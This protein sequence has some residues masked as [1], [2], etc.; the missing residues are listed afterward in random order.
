MGWPGPIVSDSASYQVFSL[1]WRQDSEPV[2]QRRRKRGQ[3]PRL[4]RV[5]R[6]GATFTS[7]IDGTR[8]RLTPEASM[9]TQEALGADI[10]LAFDQPTSPQHD[11]VY[12]EH[13]LQRTHAWAQRCLAA[14]T[15]TDQALFGV[16]QGGPFA[17]LRQ[18]SARFIGSLP[19]DGVA[20][21]TSTADAVAAIDWSMPHVPER[22]PRHVPGIGQPHELF[23]CV[24]RGI[25]QFDSN[26]PTRLAR[27]GQLFTSAGL[28]SIQDAD[29]REDARPIDSACGCA[30][31]REGF[32]RAYL[33]HLFVTDELLGYT[34]ASVH[35]LHFVLDLMRQ[36]RDAI[37]ADRLFA[38]RDEV[39]G[40]YRSTA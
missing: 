29:L 24:E 28:L 6:D 12:T 20:N 40:R 31:C 30:T 10:V 34:L 9:S 33:R 38:L 37:R 4:V 35:N 13:A 5:D 15:R 22:W 21:G 7:H 1:G 36:I 32:S 27:R 18:K 11:A 16:I 23:A 14:R 2:A 17:E 8:E 25:D 26:A 39:L 3:T 19:F